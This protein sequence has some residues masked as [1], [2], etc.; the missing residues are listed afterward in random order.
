M[1]ATYSWSDRGG[2]CFS[3]CLVTYLQPIVQGWFVYLI[4]SVL[5]LKLTSFDYDLSRHSY[6]QN[7]KEE[8]GEIS[9]LRGTWWTTGET[10]GTL[11][12]HP[13]S[14]KRGWGF[15]DNILNPE[16]NP[17]K[18]GLNKK[19]PVVFVEGSEAEAASWNISGAHDS[20]EQTKD[21]EW[22]ESEGSHGPFWKDRVEAQLLCSVCKPFICDWIKIWCSFSFSKLCFTQFDL[23]NIEM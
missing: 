13:S 5:H 8:E 17:T 18:K 23:M 20:A 12:Q 10:R 3:V 14:R 16:N 4:T 22:G 7:T 11:S 1:I 15:L 6:I 9:S 2:D 21:W 19:P